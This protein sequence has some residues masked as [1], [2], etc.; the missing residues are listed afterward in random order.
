MF[1]DIKKFDIE[2]VDR[3]LGR[4]KYQLK[5]HYET[6]ESRSIEDNYNLFNNTI[7]FK[8]LTKNSNNKLGFYLSEQNNKIDVTN[9][10]LSEIEN[11]KFKHIVYTLT[12]NNNSLFNLKNQFFKINYNYS[13]SQNAEQD[14]YSSI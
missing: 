8:F 2:Y 5:I 12:Y 1:G 11:D 10:D 3:K 13:H 14:N 7:T 6:K 4:T 9:N